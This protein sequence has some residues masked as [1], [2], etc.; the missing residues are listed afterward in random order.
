MRTSTST[1]TALPHVILATV[2]LAAAYVSAG[3]GWPS[4]A[5]ALFLSI[6]LGQAKRA[7]T[8]DLI[9]AGRWVYG[10][11]RIASGRAAAALRRW[12]AR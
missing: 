8:L 11:V 9:A 10:R 12:W 1:D 2:A 4:V 6:G 7:V 5:I 3:L